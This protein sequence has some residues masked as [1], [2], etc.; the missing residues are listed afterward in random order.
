MIHRENR[1]HVRK[2]INQYSSEAASQNKGLETE[3][4]ERYTEIYRN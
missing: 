4:D 1:R 3:N 2:S